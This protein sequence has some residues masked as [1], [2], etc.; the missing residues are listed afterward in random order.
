MLNTLSLTPRMVVIPEEL[1]HL[2]PVVMRIV[3][4]AR[5]DL[6]PLYGIAIAPG[7]WTFTRL[8][9][10]YRLQSASLATGQ[11]LSEQA[12]A[13]AVQLSPDHL[14]LLWPMTP[15]KLTVSGYYAGSL[16]TWTGRDWMTA[17][18]QFLLQHG[19]RSWHEDE[20]LGALASLPGFPAVQRTTLTNAL[21]RQPQLIRDPRKRTW[22]LLPAA[23]S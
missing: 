11:F 10:A 12:T 5:R 16:P 15:I 23:M 1:E 19:H 9:H 7:L 21:H 14:R 18:P 13:A 20:V 17:L 3:G 8:K 6:P 4:A 22:H 2:W